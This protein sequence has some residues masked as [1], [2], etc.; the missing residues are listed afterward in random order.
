M[1]NLNIGRVNQ[2][3]LTRL[4]QL[5]LEASCIQNTY[6]LSFLLEK[7]GIFFIL[8]GGGK[9][10]FYYSSKTTLTVK[11]SLKKK[12]TIAA[13]SNGARAV[14]FGWPKAKDM[15]PRQPDLAQIWLGEARFGRPQSFKKETFRKHDCWAS[16]W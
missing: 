5:D 12:S 11:N 15:A 16:G 14:R 3:R 9:R 1:D 6:S 13:E 4:I 8:P 10:K 2:I 7:G